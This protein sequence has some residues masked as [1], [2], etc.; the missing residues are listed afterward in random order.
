MRLAMMGIL[1]VAAF[2]SPLDAQTTAAQYAAARKHLV[3]HFVKGAGVKD[4][5]VLQAILETPRHEFVPFKLRDQA[6]Y[7][8]AL[9]IGDQQ[10]IS[11]PFIVAYM[12]E[13]LGTAPHHR[14]LE[15][16]TGSGYQAAVLSPLVDQ[17]YSIEIVKELGESAAK[18]LQ[19]LE[20]DN[21][22][23]KVGDGFKGWPEHAPFD[24]IIVTCSPEKVPLPLIAQLKEGGRMV[25]PVGER[26]Q[27]TLYLFRKQNGELKSEAL[28]PTLFVPMT[29]TAESRRRVQP[30]GAKPEVINGSFEELQDERD[31]VAPGWYY[32]RQMK[33]V[34]D[35]QA[36]PGEKAPQGSHY[37]KFRNVDV[38][39]ASH[40]LQ[41][42]ALDGRAVPAVEM[43]CYV[44]TENVQDFIPNHDF[45]TMAVTFYNK[46]RGELG[47]WTVGP[48]RGTEDW[49][50]VRKR[51]RVPEA[52]R[53][54][55][56]RL[57]LFGATGV[58][59][60]DDVELRVL[61]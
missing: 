40:L 51:V 38:G 60:F 28:R 34:S 5:R 56:V 22:H 12:T 39:R 44:R 10:T 52:T 3:E 18:L 47:T 25:I 14:V 49:R 57:G 61:K 11:S 21:V 37:V 8:M 31:D 32:Q 42:L 23:V 20:Y 19:R 17:V 59:C 7:D 29:G 45:C 33:V 16:G 9:P 43:S 24:R 13:S 30:N 50:R 53:E 55:I 36:P 4:P 35:E 2:A 58:V 6:Y 54:C 46:N 27:Q 15:I 41:G 26:Y 48:L 1:T